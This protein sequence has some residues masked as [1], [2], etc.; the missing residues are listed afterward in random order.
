MND[1]EYEMEMEDQKALQLEM[2]V[3]AEM[4]RTAFPGAETALPD[5]PESITDNRPTELK[6]SWAKSDKPL[7]GMYIVAL[8][9]TTGGPYAG[10]NG[11]RHVMDL[12]TLEDAGKRRLYVRTGAMAELANAMRVR[13]MPGLN[14]NARNV[15]A[16]SDAPPT[17]A[18]SYVAGFSL[19][20][21]FGYGPHKLTVQ[22]LDSAVVFAPVTNVTAKI[23]VIPI[24]GGETRGPECWAARLAPAS[25][26]VEIPWN[27][28]KEMFPLGANI[29]YFSGFAT[30]PG[31]PTEFSIDGRAISSQQLDMLRRTS[32]HW[33]D[34]ADLSTTPAVTTPLTIRIGRPVRTKA[35][36]S[37]GPTSLYTV[38]GATDMGAAASIVKKIAKKVTRTPTRQP[39]RQTSRKDRRRYELEMEN[40]RG[41][42]DEDFR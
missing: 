33:T 41:G 35:I 28:T 12:T 19:R 25:P 23:Y 42:V 18:G 9:T 27:E 38:T 14:G 36:F 30:V 34:Y 13:D 4:V 21:N 3:L 8:Y 16:Y 37:A 32:Q 6:W 7:T 26:E 20:G 15:A 24:Y 11:F 39:T 17:V 29:H 1:D 31:A 5:A 10:T 2:E 22:T 40:E